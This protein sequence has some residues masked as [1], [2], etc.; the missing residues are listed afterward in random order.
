MD[1]TEQ[2]IAHFH[3]N[4]FF[5]IPN[6]FGEEKVRM[7]ERIQREVGPEWERRDW[8]EGVNR[9]ACQFFMVG[10]T[11]LE[12]VEQPEVVDLAQRVLGCEEVH[13][14]ACGMGAWVQDGGVGRN[15]RGCCVSPGRRF[16][17]RPLL[18]SRQRLR[19]C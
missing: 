6:P 8:P 4:G 2:Q 14:G 5:L 1:V 12:M 19:R 7:V 16:F 3:R 18:R 13:V 17:R 9:L 15:R 11:V 10:E